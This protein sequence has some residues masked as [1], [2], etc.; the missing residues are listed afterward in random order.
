MVAER[1]AILPERELA[2][3][4]VATLPR[5]RIGDDVTVR[6]WAVA[7]RSKIGRRSSMGVRAFVDG[8]HRAPGSVVPDRTIMIKDK[9]VG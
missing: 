9:I 4:T 6:D 2:P 1:Q 8:S 7:F 3:T 5:T